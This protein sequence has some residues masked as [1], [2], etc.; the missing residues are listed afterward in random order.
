MSIVQ[1]VFNALSLN[2]ET[3]KLEL[4]KLMT[5]QAAEVHYVWVR[6][7]EVGMY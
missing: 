7:S 4:S 2:L 6:A 5:A 1:Y 3:R